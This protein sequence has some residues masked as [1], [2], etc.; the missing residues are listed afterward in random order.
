[1]PHAIAIATADITK[2]AGAIETFEANKKHL[3]KV[4]KIL[5]DGGWL[6][7][8]TICRKSNKAFKSGNR[9]CQKK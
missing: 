3:K 2:R 1:L 5:A 4:K 9:N 7:R 6:Y 8:Q